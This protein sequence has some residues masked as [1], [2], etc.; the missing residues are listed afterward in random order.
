M[1]RVIFYIWISLFNNIRLSYF[2]HDK[3]EEFWEIFLQL[4]VFK[5]YKSKKI[6]QVMINVNVEF[7]EN[8]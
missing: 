3:N 6:Y 1:I 2:F 8:W 5:L 4:L 7:N